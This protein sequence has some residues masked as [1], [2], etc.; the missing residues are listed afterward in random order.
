MSLRMLNI[1]R[2]AL[3]AQRG[4]LEVIGHNV[5]N[6]ETPGY[7]RQRP[8]LATIPGAVTGQPG[9]GVEL[10]EIRLLR[11][12][13]L[14]TQLRH[15]SGWLG[16]DRALRGALLQ[17]E[18][19]FTDVTQGGLAGRLEEMFDA[20]AD[21]GLDP[22]GAAPRAQVVERSQLV[23]QTISDRWH[24]IDRQR[25]E[26][27]HRLRDLVNRANS[28]AREIASVN[29]KI[30]VADATSLRNDL[31]IR[32]DGLVSE[33]AELCG[34]ETIERDD[35]SVDLL[36]GGRRFVEHDRVTELTLVDHPSQPGM[37]LVALGDAISPHGLRGEIAGRLQAR[38]DYLPKYLDHL[39]T[40]ARGLA[41]AINAQHTAG[42]DLN[43]DPAP[44]LF[45]YDPTRPA[46][47]L[48]VRQE[49]I[50]DLSLIGASQSAVV[51]GD[52][53]N[54]LA[55][56]NLRNARIFSDG[57]A[58]LSRFAAELISTIGIDAATAQV[59]MDSRELLVEN[60]RDAHQNQSGVSLDE[61]A[62]ELIRYQQ[63]YAASS[64]LMNAALEMMDLVLQLR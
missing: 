10:V 40:L 53:T 23:A 45:A 59:R 1:A 17:V 21:L 41:D 2:T 7:V 32:R 64:R 31:I 33:L 8:T 28:L 34:A 62:L 49:V 35:G 58:T 43:G 26:I 44:D 18:Q 48:R 16:Q 38:D 55:I 30:G 52:G 24:A 9:G 20:W 56:E 50:D 54:A 11:D 12:E 15:E 5:A 13:L 19:V 29:E 63:A 57:T 51:D 47:S 4:A 14:A 6:V 61:E 3:F 27:D 39:D 46:A 36:I 42:L 37:H 25:V 22:T 60:L